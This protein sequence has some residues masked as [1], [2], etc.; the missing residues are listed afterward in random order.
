MSTEIQRGSGRCRDGF[1]VAVVVFLL[2]AIAVAGATG[3][4]IVRLEAELASQG[5]EGEVALSV[6]SAGLQRYLGEQVG[7]PADSASYVIGDGTAA[8]VSRKLAEVDSVTDLYVLS[9][10][11]TV[12]DSRWPD[13]PARRTV[14]QHALLRKD[15]VGIHAAL[16]V[17][18]GNVRLRSN[19]TVDGD[20]EANP[21][22]CTNGGF[23][24]RAGIGNTGSY[25]ATGNASVDGSPDHI[26]LGSYAAIMDSVKVR[27]DVL[28]SSSFPIA[29]D[30]SPPN[31]ASIPADSFPLVRATQDLQ[32]NF[33]WSGRGV[34]IV[35]GEFTVSN[36]FSWNGIILAGS[37]GDL[38]G[39]RFFG[40]NLVNIHG[41]VIG[42]LDGS[43][44]SVE[45]RKVNLDYNSCYAMSASESLAYLEPVEGTWYEGL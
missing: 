23:F 36:F 16:T 30:G 45:L 42:G 19:A 27:W 37:L 21:G 31:W 22:D 3:Y 17:A 39:G 25:N 28:Q 14:R 1:A 35:P 15:P 6:A 4:Q 20:D 10:V 18:A 33:S 9:S 43:Q 5:R 24:D 38:E 40:F 29:H 32:G 26:Q 13:S 12:V 44:G 2:F 7:V 8:V 11:G 34:L 41:L